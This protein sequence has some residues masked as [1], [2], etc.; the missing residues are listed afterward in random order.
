MLNQILKTRDQS[1]LYARHLNSPLVVGVPHHSP[2]GSSH[3]PTPDLRPGDENAGFL[4]AYIAAKLKASL[5]ITCNYTFDVNKTWFSDYT[6]IIRSWRPDFLLEIHGH[7]GNNT[8]NDIEISCG[9]PEKSYLAE[10]L[11]S[12]LHFRCSRHNLLQHLRISGKFSDIYY[13]ATMSKTITCDSWKGIH[14]ELPL[15]LRKPGSGLSGKPS[16]LGYE[17]SRMLVATLKEILTNDH[18]SDGKS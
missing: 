6:R 2:Y 10:Q 4:G 5:L 1:V 8:G 16:H 15:C 18:D 12:N 13:Q 9:K 3:L 17:F 11:A 7:G 14:I